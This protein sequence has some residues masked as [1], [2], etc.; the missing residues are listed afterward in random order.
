M[1]L[2]P[3]I[4]EQFNATI[5]RMEIDEIS[6]TIFI[7]TRNNEDRQV[8]FSAIDLASGKTYFKDFTT[9]E[10]WL[11]GIETAC[12]GVLLL[13]N[14]QTETGPTHTTYLHTTKG[15][16]RVSNRRLIADANIVNALA[17]E[18]ALA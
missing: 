3:H 12:N 6:D 5:W 15:W 8:A 11:T 16:R 2:S 7:E 18:K 10:R 17:H 13:H 9:P 1:Q 4:N 14:Y